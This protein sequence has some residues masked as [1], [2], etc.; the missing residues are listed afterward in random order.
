MGLHAC[1]AL[2][3]LAYSNLRTLR[4]LEIALCLV[5]LTWTSKLKFIINQ[6]KYLT[7]FYQNEV[8]V[9]TEDDK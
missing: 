1:N 5:K 2:D 3:F 8:N 4:V 6:F 9:K 7:H